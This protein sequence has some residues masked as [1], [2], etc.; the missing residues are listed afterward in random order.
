MGHNGEFNTISRFRLEAAMLG[1]ELAPDNSDSQD[2]DRVLHTLCLNFGL[3]L[4]EAMELVFPPHQHDLVQN[5]RSIHDV[6][7]QMRRS[8]GPFAQGPAAVA[9]RFGDQC[10]FAVDALG[11]RPLWFGETEKEYF[12][13]SERG[14][15]PLTTIS[16]NPKPLAPG[17]KVALKITPGR[18]V[19]VLNYP[20]IQHHV[21]QRHQERGWRPEHELKDRLHDFQRRTGTFPALPKSDTGNGGNSSSGTMNAPASAAVLVAEAPAPLPYSTP[22]TLTVPRP[23]S[24]T[25]PLNANT[26]AALGWER[27]HVSVVQTMAEIAKEQVGSL[28]WDGP[29]AA[30]S[31]TRMNIADY[32]K[33]TVAVVTN[34]AIDRE[35]EQAQFSIKT[36]LGIRPGI[37]QHRDE[38]I[39]I[40]LQTPFLTGGSPDLGTADDMNEVAQRHGTMTLE[41]VIGRFGSHVLIV[42]TATAADESIPQALNRIQ[43]SVLDAVLN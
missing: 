15:Y 8:F 4:I 33:E 3:D 6:Y 20:A 22:D 30:L 34:P 11:L 10:V 32:F 43:G 39:C 36:L 2:V 35:R 23:W 29:L 5:I 41:E 26:L 9:A 18:A 27:Y 21:L 16:S 14:V 24:E 42:S 25:V 13:S 28:G 17:E 38:A 31:Q 1:I 37:G 19:E 7:E 12:A 40:E